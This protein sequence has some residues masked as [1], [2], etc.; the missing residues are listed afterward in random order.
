MLARLDLRGFTGDLIAAVARR[1]AADDTEKVAAVGEIVRTVRAQGDAALRDYTAR[2]DDCTVDEL[3]VPPADLKTALESIPTEL[4]DALEYARAEI[5][6]YHEAQVV[7]EIVHERDGVHIREVMVPVDRAGC[8]VPGGRASYPSTVLMTTIPARVAGVPEVALCVPPAVDGS[9]PEATLAAAQLVG[10]DEVYRVG[11]AQAIAAL[12]YGT[13]SIRAADVVYGP[14]NEYVALAKRAVAADVATDYAG[15]S[16]IVAVADT[17]VRADLVAIDLLAQAEHGPGGHVVLV[18]WDEGV[19]DAVDAAV[20][21]LL[22]EAP[23]REDIESTLATGGRSVLVDD[24]EQALAVANAIAPEHLELLTADVE[25][26]VPL[27]RN[28]GAVFCGPWTPT[29]VGDYVA[30]TNH[31]L[32]TDRAA[33]FASALRVDS[34]LKHVHIVTMDEP[35]L[36]RVARH[37]QALAAVEGLD[38]HARSVTLRTSETQRS[39]GRATGS[40]KRSRP[41]KE[42]QP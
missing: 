38:E 29:V 10:V 34:F 8:Y 14:G 18:T 36:R 23:R 17:T 20:D 22:A 41:D 31:M 25:N 4:R 16:E 2:F 39:A 7:P 37:I 19:A 42:G 1:P 15:P 24:V 6:A 11:G 33:R 26:L 30:G 3:R 27:V 35:A 32:P 12:A 28:A 5:T 21:A 9:V 40:A 13:E